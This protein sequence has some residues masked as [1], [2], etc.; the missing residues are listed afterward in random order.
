MKTV[1][2][3]GAGF[4]GSNLAEELVNS[5]HEVTILD[6]LSTG[7]IE[8]I[9][10]LRDNTNFTFINGSITDLD[11]LKRVFEDVECVFHQAA[12][13]SVQRSVEDPQATN[14]ANVNGTLNVLIAARDCGVEKVIYVRKKVVRSR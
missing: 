1:V 10:N 6:N 13:P 9:T 12:I 2:T 14:E 7:R 5:N 3:G 4:I 11:I 8:N